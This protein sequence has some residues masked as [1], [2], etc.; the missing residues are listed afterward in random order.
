MRMWKKTEKL[1]ASMEPK[2]AETVPKPSWYQL[3]RMA[4]AAPSDGEPAERLA[5]GLRRGEHGL[6]EHDRDAED[7]EDELGQQGEDVRGH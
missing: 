4:A 2:K 1:L 5:R 3:A 7:G 6:G